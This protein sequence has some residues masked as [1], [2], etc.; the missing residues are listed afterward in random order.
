MTTVKS[1]SRPGSALLAGAAMECL[2]RED[3]GVFNGV[4]HQFGDA[5][6]F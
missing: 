5:A 6:D 4:L 2:L 1:D 3:D